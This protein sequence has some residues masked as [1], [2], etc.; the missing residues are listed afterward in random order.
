MS[1]ISGQELYCWYRQAKK[2]AIANNID[3]D[4]LDW[5]LQTVTGLN[6]LSLRLGT[7]Q[8]QLITSHKSLSELKQLW[9]QR[10]QEHL[11]V[12]YLAETVFWRRFRLKVT[13]AVLIP[14][15]ETELI[16]DI[17]KEA[18]RQSDLKSDRHWVDLGTGSGA[19]ALGLADSFP[20]ATIHAVDLSEDALK[21][22]SENAVKLKLEQNIRFYQGS[23]WSPLKFLQGR[24]SGM[25]SNPPYIPTPQ[26][27]HLQPEVV[28]HEPRLAL[29]GG[30]DG[31]NDIRYLINTAP[32]Y[33]VSGGI[34][35]I[36]MM[37]GQ[38]SAVAELLE[39]QGEYRDVKL[40]CDLN[41]VERFALAYRR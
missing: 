22:A 11:P 23:W 39:Q 41:N 24:V 21:V 1:K 36:E 25:V 7:F 30:D 40:F 15:P 4:E 8:D 9:Q 3:P 14:R 20:Q 10:L 16:I 26:L 2:S 17:A 31:L 34:W 37:T 5:L 19:I 6:S 27:K 29:D 35:L 28:K 38:S 13:P 12:Q 32:Q 33:L 18:E